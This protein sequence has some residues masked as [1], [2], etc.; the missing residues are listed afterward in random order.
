MSAHWDER[1]RSIGAEAVSW[2]QDRPTTSL[3]LIDALGATSDA[4]VVDIGGGASVLVDHLLAEGHR[5]VTVLDVSSAGL[6]VARDRLGDPPEVTWVQAD[7][8]AWDPPR[9][10]DLWHDRAVLHFLTDGDDRTAYVELMRRSLAPGGAFVIGTF[11]TDGPTHCSGLPVHRYD[12]DALVELL[13]GLDAVDIVASRR[14][15]HH[16]PGDAEQPFTWIAGRLR[17]HPEGTAT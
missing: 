6:D 3:D 15:V 13:G 10:W 1:Y 16:T 2:Y 7:L 5:D 12:S 17:S 9:R 8:L 14:E 4:S 11:A